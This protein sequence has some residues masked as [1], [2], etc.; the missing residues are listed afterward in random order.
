MK[1]HATMT[2]I[3]FASLVGAMTATSVAV[4]ADAAPTPCHSDAAPAA[5]KAPAAN[6]DG[7]D[8]F[9]DEAGRP[10][11]GWEYLFNSPG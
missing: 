8:R 7:F 3:V 6:Y 11:P 9:R 5:A 1:T 10:L 2:A 4:A